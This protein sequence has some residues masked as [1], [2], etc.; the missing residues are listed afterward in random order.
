[1]IFYAYIL[2]GWHS[3][4]LNKQQKIIFKHQHRIPMRLRIIIFQ[5]LL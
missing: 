1:M 2:G 3:H 4:T 5:C